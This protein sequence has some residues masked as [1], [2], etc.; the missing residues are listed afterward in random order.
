MEYQED[1]KMSPVLKTPDNELSTEQQHWFWALTF[2]RNI[3]LQVVESGQK[4][5]LSCACILTDSINTPNTESEMEPEQPPP[6]QG[7]SPIIRPE[8]ESL[9]MAMPC[10]PISETKLHVVIDKTQDI[11]PELL[12]NTMEI[13]LAQEEVFKSKGI[14]NTANSSEQKYEKGAMGNK[15]KSSIQR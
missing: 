4:P 13:Y 10:F 14:G 5:H 8:V 9:E 11:I 2:L 1:I 3:I 15:L 6:T 12:I 7:M